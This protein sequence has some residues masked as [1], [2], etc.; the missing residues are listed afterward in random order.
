MTIT[1][2]RKNLKGLKSWWNKNAKPQYK[3]TLTAKELENEC[4]SE[5]L[6]TGSIE[7]RSFQN[8]DNRTLTYSR[9]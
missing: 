9:W 1:E 6:N 7:M 3:T 4:L 8:K 2:A 5:M